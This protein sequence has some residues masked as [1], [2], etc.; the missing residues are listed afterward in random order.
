MILNIKRLQGTLYSVYING[1][2]INTYDMGTFVENAYNYIISD[3]SGTTFNLNCA[4]QSSSEKIGYFET[5]F[6]NRILN[7]QESLDLHN[8]FANKFFKLFIGS[9]S[10]SLDIK[11]NRVRL[12]NIFNLAGKI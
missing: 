4:S 9:N 12:P 7:T 1:N 11:S 10:L 5:V 8:F 2:L 3:L 6:Y